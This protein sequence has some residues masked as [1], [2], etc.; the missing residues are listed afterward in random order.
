MPGAGKVQTQSSG[1]NWYLKES[2]RV[3]VGEREVGREGTKG[4]RLRDRGLGTEG[5]GR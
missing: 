3:G 2:E 1:R 5:G 4:E